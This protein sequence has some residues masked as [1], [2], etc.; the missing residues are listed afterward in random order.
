MRMSKYEATVRELSVS[1]RKVFECVPIE[2]EWTAFRIGAE[3]KRKGTPKDRRLVD[4]C[5]AALV[6]DGLITHHPIKGTFQRIEPRVSAP[7]ID[8]VTKEEVV[9]S[10]RP[11]HMELMSALADRA[12]G[13]SAEMKKLAD[14]IEAAA[15]TIDEEIAQAGKDTTKLR[16]LQTLLKELT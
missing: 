12:R 7:V 6:R 3:L 5:L 1:A 8:M 15:V 9:S 10:A 16:Q 4:G 14:D 13:L 11:N 2:E